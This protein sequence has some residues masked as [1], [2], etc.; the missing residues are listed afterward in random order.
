MP[1]LISFGVISI[2]N[3]RKVILAL[4]LFGRG[5]TVSTDHHDRLEL[6]QSAMLATYIQGETSVSTF[7]FTGTLFF[8]L[9][10]CGFVCYML[11]N[12]P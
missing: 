3:L 10:I 12:N 5:L 9:K 4:R 7:E 2:T 11:M 6:V 1:N 8:S